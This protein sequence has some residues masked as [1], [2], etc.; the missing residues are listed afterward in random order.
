VNERAP[1]VGTWRIR[2]M[3]VWSEDAFDLL[4]PA[5]FTFQADGFGTFRFIAVEGDMD[6]RFG[7]RDGKPLVEFSEAVNEWSRRTEAEREA[8]GQGARSAWPRRATSDEQ[9]SPR[10]SQPAECSRPF[11]HSLS[12]EGGDDGDPMTGRGWAVVDGEVLCGHIFLHCGDDSAFTATREVVV[13]PRR[14]RPR[15]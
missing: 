2:T 14:R 9:R 10:A 5:H 6:C 11:V 4:G 12:W 8:R 3:E 1:F 15:R 13:P 7:E